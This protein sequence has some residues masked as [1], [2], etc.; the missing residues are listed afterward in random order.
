[1]KYCS[2]KDVNQL[3]RQLIRQGWAFQSG[4]KHGRLISPD[5]RKTLTVSKSPS[6]SRCLH[7]IQCDIRKLGLK[8]EAMLTRNT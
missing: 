4:R 7:N 6:D 8:T 3:I 2:N 1:M 5:S